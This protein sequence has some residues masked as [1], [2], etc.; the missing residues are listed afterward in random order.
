MDNEAPSKDGR[1]LDHKTL[2][3]IRMRAVRRVQEGESPEVVIASLGMS[4]ACIYNWLA[5]Y[6]A[7][8]WDGLRAKPLLGRPGKLQARHIRWLYDAV[9]MKNPMQFKFPFA[10]WTRSMI[11]ELLR[12]KFGI[13]LSSTSVGRLL[14]QLGLTCQKPLFRAYQQNPT[15]VEQWLQREYPSIRAEAR[16]CGADIYFGDEAGVRSDFRAGTTWAPVG[17][18]PVVRTTGARFGINMISAISPRGKMR[19]MVVR[20]KIAATQFGDFLKRLMHGAKR[21]VFLIVDGHPM[22]KAKSVKRIVDSFDGKLRLFLLPPYSPELNPD[23]LV[24]NDLKNHGVG[25]R[26][27]HSIEHLENIVAS[28]LRSLQRMPAK[29]RSFFCAKH[30]AYAA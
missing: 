20:G 18:T 10:L 6:R 1:K 5:A 27:V 24:W 12:K 13:R 30:T 25:K 21:K 22:H 15:L 16:K 9:T 8:G 14:A 7:H 17:Q 3:E 11:A 28:H 4:R 26:I 23:E 29:I 2:E 19:F